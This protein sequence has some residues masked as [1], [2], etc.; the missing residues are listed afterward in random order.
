MTA[1]AP[2][3]RAVALVV[4]TLFAL[5]TAGPAFVAAATPAQEPEQGTGPDAGSDGEDVQPRMRLAHQ[6]LEVGAD[7]RFNVLLDVVDAPPGSDIAV[8]IYDR[9][10]DLEDL[11]SPVTDP[12]PNILDTFL[13]PLPLADSPSARQTVGFSLSLFGPDDD[14]P[15]G[16]GATWAP[17]RLTE[18]GVYPLRIRLRGPDQDL[19]A[20]M[21][22]YLVRG[23]ADDQPVVPTRIALVPTIHQPSVLNPEGGPPV[24]V[25]PDLLDG[26]DD[27]LDLLEEHPDLPVS[28]SITPETV[29][30]MAA[31][32]AAEATLDR[33]R[34]AVAAPSRDVLGSPYVEIDATALAAADLGDELLRQ[35]SLG[36]RVL[37]EHLGVPGSDTWRLDGLDADTV[38]LVQAAGVA[39]AIV[40]DGAL[41]PQRLLSPATTTGSGG[42][43]LPVLAAGRF[44]IDGPAE[45]PELGAALLAGRLAATATIEPGATVVVPVDP[46]TVDVDL[47]SALLDRLDDPSSFYATIPLE[48]AFEPAAGTAPTVAPSPSEPPDLGGFPAQVR[49]THERLASY[50]SMVPDQPELYGLLERPLARSAS[51]DLEPG[52]RRALLDRVDAQ[53]QAGFD[54]ISIPERDRVTL[55]ARD[56]RFPLPIES[57]L[58]GPVQVV[59]TLEA[60]DRLE[61]R[62]ERIEA[63][64]TGERTL[65]QIP[66]Q[67]RV[68]GDTPLRITVHTPDGRV[69]LGESRYRI[70]STAVS[71]VG[72]VLTVG[73]AAFLAVWWGRHW[74]RTSRERS[75]HRLATT[76]AGAAPP[77]RE[78]LDDDPD[79]LFVH[80]P[81]DDTHRP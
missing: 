52:E 58:D 2:R 36:G 51:R 64:L 25:D 14:R 33:L 54:S 11:T 24:P 42:E 28:F 39:R 8:D 78:A 57:D 63:T 56:A 17:Y 31:D 47:L 38:A 4:G 81:D 59:I 35:A 30:L 66:V 29:D 76:L 65:V 21:V 55:G 5:T 19:V 53:L 77:D 67:T 23:P 16:T 12:P 9:V 43:V 18:P 10:T 79:D 32:P 73:A 37:D 22:T 1:R 6:D 72:V 26:V 41:A 60:S 49:S 48:D 27:L 7:G 46:G 69:L 70:R 15:D 13:P 75:A 68:T 61:F 45:D 74:H 44:T 40:P 62:E 20:S 80:G 34:T 3:R 71:G 50:L